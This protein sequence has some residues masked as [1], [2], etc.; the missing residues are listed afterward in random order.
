MRVR[1][2]G[3]RVSI[4]AGIV[5]FG[6]ILLRF[7]PSLN[8]EWL[9]QASIPV[10]PGGAELNA[11]TALAKWGVPVRYSSVLPTNALADELIDYVQGKGIDTGGFL[12]GGSRI[13]SYYLPQGTDLK[14][15][16]VIYDRAYSAFSELKAGTVDWEAVLG[17]A[18]WLH[19]SAIS[20]ALS[21]PVADACLELV[22]V[23]SARGLRISI[24][25]NYR[26]RLWQYGVKP[27]AVMPAIVAHC[28]LVM[29]NLWAAEA[30]LDIPVDAD[31]HQRGT[32]EAYIAHAERT[33]GA[34]RERFPRCRWV[35]NTFR[36]NAEG[37][38]IRYYA[39]LHAGSETVVSPLFESQS[40]V[41]QVGSGDCFMAGLLYGLSQDHTLQDTVDFAAAAAFGKLH[42]R[43]DATNQTTADVR[44]T[45]NTHRQTDKSLS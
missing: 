23:A 7:S 22:Q 33:A 1:L 9:R 18:D 14:N 39:S 17:D 43:G 12:R 4:M 42:E 30:L 28:D 32:Q 37:G 13:G 44:R 40:V 25:L 8:G 16:G 38:G 26:A 29:G 3:A 27:T 15:A 24:D 35:A 5:C 10:Y 36:F 2:R 21:Q 34:I 6:E 45:L 31:I 19:L 20:P 11:A 41:D